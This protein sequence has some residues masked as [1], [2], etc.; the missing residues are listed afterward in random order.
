MGGS[1]EGRK[2]DRR[3]CREIKWE[4][5]RRWGKKRGRRKKRG[6]SGSRIDDEDVGQ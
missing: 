6:R 5:K 4:K 2:R 3:I 1:K